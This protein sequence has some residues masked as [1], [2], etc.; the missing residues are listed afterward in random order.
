MKFSSMMLFSAL[1]ALLVY[2][3]VCHW[4]WGGGWLAD[5]G[6]M[7]F[8]GGI[9]IP[10][11]IPV[12][13]PKTLGL[14]KRIHSITIQVKEPAAA[15]ICVTNIAI[16]AEPSAANA[17]PALNPNQPTHNIPAPV[18]TMVSLVS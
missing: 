6:V 11:T 9:V 4:V 7:D 16:P 18:T 1:W 15:L 5:M 2:V 8:A 14:P 12:T 3:P 13:I 10:A 17:L